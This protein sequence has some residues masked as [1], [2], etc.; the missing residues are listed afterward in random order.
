MKTCT[1]PSSHTTSYVLVFIVPSQGGLSDL[2]EFGCKSLYHPN[3]LPQTS[4]G[5]Q[6]RH[7]SLGCK[8]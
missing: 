3:T 7:R 8:K 5:Y 1:S 6:I 4:L 2:V